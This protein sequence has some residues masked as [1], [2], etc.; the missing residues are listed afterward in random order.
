MSTTQHEAQIAGRYLVGLLVSGALLFSSAAFAASTDMQDLHKKPQN[1]LGQE[2]EIVGV[3]V[4]GGK[5]GDVLG[6]ECTT[7]EGIYVDARDVEPE[8]VKKKLDGGCVG[9]SCRVTIRFMPHSYT[10]SAVVEP[11]KDITIFSADKATVSSESGN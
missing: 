6:Y 7:E 10:T 11:G 9:D 8:T 5:K 3:C 4:K 2:V 1:Y